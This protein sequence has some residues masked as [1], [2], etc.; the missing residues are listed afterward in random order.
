LLLRLV[1]RCAKLFQLAEL[2][3]DQ[4]LLLIGQSVSYPA[5]I[6]AEFDGRHPSPDGILAD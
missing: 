3:G 6:P 2:G 5:K 4:L 1:G